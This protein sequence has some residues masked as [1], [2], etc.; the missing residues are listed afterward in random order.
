MYR[1]INQSDKPVMKR[2]KHIDR[3][4]HVY[5]SHLLDSVKYNLYLENLGYCYVKY[6]YIKNYLS[7]TDK[8]LTKFLF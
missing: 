3:I 2:E 7:R 6:D 4:Y 8:L 1:Q 5:K